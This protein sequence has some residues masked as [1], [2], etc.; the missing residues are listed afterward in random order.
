MFKR[1]R[2]FFYY[3]GEFKTYRQFIET[4]WISFLLKDGKIFLDWFVFTMEKMRLNGHKK[5]LILL[6]LVLQQY[7]NYFFSKLDVLGVFF[8]IRGK[9]GVSGNAKKRHKKI[10]IG[11]NSST[12]KILK[13]NY[14]QSIIRTSTGVLG[15]SFY[16]Y[17]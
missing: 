16:I 5:F 9:I 1:L 8:D 6:K 14:K 10:S 15:V 12:K 4:L 17:F 7:Y 13:I 11:S 3:I 2:K